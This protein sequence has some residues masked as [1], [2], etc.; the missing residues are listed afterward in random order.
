MADTADTAP[1]TQAPEEQKAHDVEYADEE[2]KQSVS[3]GFHSF[4]TGPSS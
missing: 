2:A 3:T 1:S 4:A